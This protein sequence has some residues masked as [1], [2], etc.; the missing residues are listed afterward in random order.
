MARGP[1]N[2]GAASAA[3]TTVGISAIIMTLNEEA[4][5]RPCLESL[6]GVVDEIFL[7]DSGST[8]GTTKIAETL[9]ATVIY[10]PPATQAVIL[11]WA[12]ENIDFRGD[13]IL[14][15]D[16]DERLTPELAAELSGLGAFPP[17]TTGLFVKRRV[18]FMGR[19]MRHGG[20]YP[21]WIVRAWRR[22]AAVSEQ[23][24][25]D[26]HMVLRHG[27][28]GYLRHDIIEENLKGLHAWIERQNRYATREVDALLAGDAEEG[29][30]PSL[31]GTPEARRR[32][33]KKNVLMAAPP[34]LRAFLFFGYRYFIRFGF[35]DGKEGFIFHFLHGCWYRFLIDAKVHERKLQRRPT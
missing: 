18:Y 2:R 23:R 10:H 27:E 20:Y 31:R 13:W 16:A 9:G 33:L 28:P 15:L 26:E 24:R 11:N 14:R 19:W 5:I 7:V 8:D 6:R 22:G 25:M 21:I 32:W 29:I 35:L 4:N 1:F 17:T 30:K 12:L 3:T 34:F